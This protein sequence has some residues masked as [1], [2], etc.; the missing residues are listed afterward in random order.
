MPPLWR[1]RSIGWSARES[2][3]YGERANAVAPGFIATDMLET[4]LVPL[5]GRLR[6]EIPLQR[7]GRANELAQAVLFLLQPDTASF[8]TGE[9]LRVNGGH[10]MLLI[11]R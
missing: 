1:R 2:A 9:V 10:H 7:F 3:S 11:V 4:I 6:T 8:I 5:P